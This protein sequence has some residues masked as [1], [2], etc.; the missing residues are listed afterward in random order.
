M[1]DFSRA[2]GAFSKSQEEG[3]ARFP[4]NPAPNWGPKTRASRTAPA[5]DLGASKPP[6]PK[7]QRRGEKGE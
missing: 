7:K 3:V 6:P 2:K 5:D 4:V 1:A